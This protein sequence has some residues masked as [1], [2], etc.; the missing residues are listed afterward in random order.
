MGLGHL[1]AY[2]LLLPLIFPYPKPFE[3]HMGHSKGI[4]PE[5]PYSC[6][7][8]GMGKQKGRTPLHIP[9][10]EGLKIYIFRV[11]FHFLGYGMNNA[12]PKAKGMPYPIGK[13]N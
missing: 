9:C 8:Q 3:G 6:P 7:F 13:G 4:G 10:P 2:W 11:Y 5:S 1:G 12:L